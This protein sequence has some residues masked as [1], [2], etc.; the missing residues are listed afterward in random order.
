MTGFIETSYNS[1]VTYDREFRGTGGCLSRR[2][3]VRKAIMSERRM[4]FAALCKRLGKSAPYIRTLQV[5]LTLPIPDD[6]RYSESYEKFMR[7]LV[8]LRTL[9][10]PFEEIGALL[11]LEKKLLQLLNIDT[12]EPSHTWFLDGYRSPSASDSCLLIT[13]YD[14]SGLIHSGGVQSQLDFSGRKAE[15]FSGSEMGEDARRV[16]D[17]WLERVQAIRARVRTEVP[18][19]RYS[20][21]WAN[22]SVH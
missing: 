22:H 5:R 13:G 12:L 9:S 6:G 2:A 11:A 17:L 14:L 20:L 7:G 16:Y 21:L 15:L 1:L 8:S 4:D 3:G 19:L 10:V 18:I